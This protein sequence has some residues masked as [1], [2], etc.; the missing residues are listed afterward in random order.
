M[1]RMELAR[2]TGI[3]F[4]FSVGWTALTYHWLHRWGWGGRPLLTSASF[5][6][7]W[8]GYDLVKLYLRGGFTRKDKP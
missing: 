5:M 3:G 7:G 8:T 4:M 2:S 6:L 1:T